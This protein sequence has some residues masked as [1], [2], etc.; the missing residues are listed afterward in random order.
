MQS[1]IDSSFNKP[2]QA[3]RRNTSTVSPNEKHSETRLRSQSVPTDIANSL[4]I[5]NES[6]LMGILAAGQQ[7]FVHYLPDQRKSRIFSSVRIKKERDVGR[8]ITRYVWCSNSLPPYESLDTLQWASIDERGRPK[9]SGNGSVSLQ[10]LLQVRLGSVEGG[11]LRD[12]EK[13]VLRGDGWT[14]KLLSENRELRM[15]WLKA[16]RWLLAQLQAQREAHENHTESN[17]RGNGGNRD[18][19]N[20]DGNNGDKEKESERKDPEDTKENLD[21]KKQT[22]GAEH[23]R[24]PSGGSIATDGLQFSSNNPF[25]DGFEMNSDTSKLETSL[26]YDDSESESDQE[27]KIEKDS[28]S[29][30]SKK[31]NSGKWWIGDED[32]S[33]YSLLLLDRTAHDMSGRTDHSWDGQD[34]KRVELERS[35]ESLREELR[36]MHSLLRV[37]QRELEETTQT[38]LHCIQDL[39]MR[40]QVLLF[41][42]KKK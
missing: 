17:Y 25:D 14:I 1:L 23:S 13:I 11:I 37:K 15:D 8:W 5:E 31:R 33:E 28:H 27:C 26:H 2:V 6:Y 30:T 9:T 18:D 19:G 24:E 16:L 20:S 35:I 29:I 34:T 41:F 40:L 3:H 36:E 4:T 10:E 32:E 39:Q 38:S 42:L 21:K 7:F 12:G 22:K